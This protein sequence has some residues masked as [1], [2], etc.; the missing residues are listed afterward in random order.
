MKRPFAEVAEMTLD[1]KAA[2]LRLH[3]ACA[4]LGTAA[5]ERLV[6]A[7]RKA[8]HGLSASP[9]ASAP[10]GSASGGEEL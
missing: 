1:E 4:G 2:I 3:A 8:H 5:I 9:D 10:E 6:E 7:L